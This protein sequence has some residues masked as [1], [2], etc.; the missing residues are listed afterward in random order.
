MA[1]AIVL[2]CDGEYVD[3]DLRWTKDTPYEHDVEQ[4]RL[5][6]N[7]DVNKVLLIRGDGTEL[8]DYT[9]VGREAKDDRKATIDDIIEWDIAGVSDGNGREISYSYSEEDDPDEYYPGWE[10]PSDK[11]EE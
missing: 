4:A 5:L 10:P 6:Y 3:H 1:G 9:L 7:K 8:R 11:G 2:D